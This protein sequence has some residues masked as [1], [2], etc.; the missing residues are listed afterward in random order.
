[1]KG[2]WLRPCS[3]RDDHN[4]RARLRPSLHHDDNAQATWRGRQRCA[5]K[6]QS[7]GRE[8]DASV[9][10]MGNEVNLT[11][12]LAQLELEAES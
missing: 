8:A 1:M 4:G 11:T 9:C 6:R 10:W 7:F 2:A 3:H 12:F 5:A